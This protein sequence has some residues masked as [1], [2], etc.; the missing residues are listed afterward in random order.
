[1]TRRFVFGLAAGLIALSLGAFQAQA[2]QVNLPSA[3]TPLEVAGNYAVVGGLTFSNFTYVTTPVGS[4]P[5][6]DNVTVSS[7]T[8]IP[9]E[10]GISFNGIFGA[11]AGQTVDYAITYMVKAAPGTMI[12]D[13]YLSLAGFVNYGGTGSVAIGETI[14]NTTGGTL[15]QMQVF[16]PS[17]LMDT[18]LL[19]PASGTIVVQKDIS[20]FGGTDGAA[21]SFV[22]QGFS[23]S[24]IP[25]PT[26]LALLGIGLSGLFSI[27][28]F[29]KRAIA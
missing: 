21:F 8:S 28:R 4:P 29:L 7:F 24:A 2:G 22:N 9:G 1:M 15:G 16:T 5:T 11:A 6:S 17:Q 26:S 14:T 12:T 18:T 25:E 23:T 27:R 19:M 20:V 3:L 13:A 10:T